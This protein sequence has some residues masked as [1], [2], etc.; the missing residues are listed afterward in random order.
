MFAQLMP[1]HGLW[2]SWTVNNDLIPDDIPVE[3]ASLTSDEVRTISIIHP[4]LKVVVLPGGQFGEE[5]SVIHF[6]F[7]VQRVM[8]HLPYPLSES[9]VILSISCAGLAQRETFQTMLERINQ[10]R[11]YQA[12]MWLRANN[13]LY[14]SILVQDVD[15]M[16]HSDESQT[17]QLKHYHPL[18][19]QQTNHYLVTTH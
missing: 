5:G 17:T 4:F 19:H 16:A 10:E 6:P 2:P 18:N 9:E 14:S 3:L 13:T 7:P 12:L 8:N 1:C 15:S 11:V